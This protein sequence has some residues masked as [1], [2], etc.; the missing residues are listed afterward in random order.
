M[1]NKP[2]MMC[3]RIAIVLFSA[4]CLSFYV[5]CQARGPQGDA[6]EQDDAMLSGSKSAMVAPPG[7]DWRPISSS[8]STVIVLPEGAFESDA[9]MWSSKSGMIE[10]N[11]GE[12]PDLDE[13]FSSD[14]TDEA[15]PS[16]EPYRGVEL[17]DTPASA[18]DTEDS[19]HVDDQDPDTDAGGPSE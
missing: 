5:A 2:L 9:L 12:A 4:A 11:T 17:E 13:L 18:D 10:F 6:P 19:N 14:E 1:K 7:D 8:K 16:D 15:P 3:L